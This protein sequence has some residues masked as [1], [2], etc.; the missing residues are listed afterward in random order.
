MCGCL[1]EQFGMVGQDEHG[2]EL[3]GCVA[4]GGSYCAISDRHARVRTPAR[5]QGAERFTPH[6]PHTKCPHIPG[7]H[8]PC[9]VI[10]D[11]SQH[12]PPHTPPT[13]TKATHAACAVKWNASSAVSVAPAAAVSPSPSCTHPFHSSTMGPAWLCPTPPGPPT[14]VL[15]CVLSEGAAVRPAPAGRGP[16]PST[17]DVPA[18]VD[19]TLSP[20]PCGNAC[21][22]CV[23]VCALSNRCMRS[24]AQL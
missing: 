12:P 18:V 15:G 11:H 19:G 6:L 24:S 17:P 9:R 5:T 8:T 7:F 10:S 20:N 14:S 3:T 22:V 16:P 23:G 13:H 1:R 4:E 21:T 2:P